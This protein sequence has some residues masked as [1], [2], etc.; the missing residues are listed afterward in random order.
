MTDIQFTPWQE[1]FHALHQRIAGHFERAEPRR[2]VFT[3]LQG[4]IS[5]CER[6]NGWQLAEH[7]GESSPDGVQ[8]LL[9]QAHWSALE[10]RRGAR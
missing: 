8:R 9:N 2:R 6:K 3:Y 5:S 10:R 4:L 7:A 1:Q